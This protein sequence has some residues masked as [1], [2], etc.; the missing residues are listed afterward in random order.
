MLILE[1]IG[2]REMAGFIFYW[3]SWI[4]W[5]YTTFIMDKKQKGRFFISFSLLMAIIL[6]VHYI[7][8]LNV[9]VS[10]ATLFLVLIS[11]FYFYKSHIFTL[12]NIAIRTLIISFSGATF[13]LMAL[14]D[15]FWIIIDL[16]W[17]QGGLFMVMA[18]LLFKEY[19][20]R[21]L[22]TVIGLL[23]ADIIYGYF[24]NQLNI[25][26]KIGSFEYMDQIAVVCL[27]ISI[28]YG[29]EH[30]QYI[31]QRKQSTGKGET[32]IK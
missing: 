2:G 27:F 1:N 10:F 15:P 25:T 5:I 16:K 21:I 32:I 20:Y 3:L 12:I 17:I 4:A 30:I 18:S 7:V 28:W 11:Y 23:Q 24:L 13:L 14:Y 26:Y 22:S 31:F 29:L 9:E 6:S 19:K 8:I